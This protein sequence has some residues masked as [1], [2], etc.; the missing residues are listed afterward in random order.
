MTRIIVATLYCTTSIWAEQATWK[1]LDSNEVVQVQTAARADAPFTNTKQSAPRQA[2]I[3]DRDVVFPH[4]AIGGGWETVI[5]IVNMSNRRVDYRIHYFDQGGVPMR[6]TIRN[7]PSGEL[8][9]GELTVGNLPPGHSFNFSLFDDGGP[10][11]VGWALLDYDTSGGR[12]GGYA[13]FRRLRPGPAIPEAMIPLS[14]YNDS[15]FVMP[16]DNIQGFDTAIAIVNPG[17]SL[18]TT[19]TLTFLTLDGQLIRQITMRLAPGEQTAFALR[20]R[21]PEIAGRLG[22]LLVEGSTTRLS[23]LGIRFSPTGTFSSVPIMN[24]SGLF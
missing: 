22:T 15:I 20:D 3:T 11:R 5:V 10:T 4:L 12:I 17:S 13:I 16:F 2:F 21:V 8:A 1:M 14:A 19:I 23:A 9:S 6:T 7:Y 24:W 18:T